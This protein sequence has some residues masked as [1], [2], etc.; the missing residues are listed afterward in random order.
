[1][2]LFLIRVF[3]F[4]YL[5]PDTKKLLSNMN[6]LDQRNVGKIGENTGNQGR[7]EP[8]V[9]YILHSIFIQ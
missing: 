6:G 4:D 9:I 3:R 7:I 1:M 2:S 5:H 8:V